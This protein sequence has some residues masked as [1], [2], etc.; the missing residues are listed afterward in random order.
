M[1]KFVTAPVCL[2]LP[3]LFPWLK[4]EFMVE[5]LLRLDWSAWI[6]YFIQFEFVFLS[7]FRWSGPTA[8]LEVLCY[9]M[10]DLLRQVVVLIKTYRRLIL[11]TAGKRCQT[12]STTKPFWGLQRNI[13]NL[14]HMF[15]SGIFYNEALLQSR[16]ALP[17]K[18]LLVIFRWV[19]IV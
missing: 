2:S 8:I 6:S 16:K 1:T 17:P 12:F 18:G 9:D 5:N 7:Y 10:H 13:T 11:L 3:I 19:F 4:T 15:C 14:R